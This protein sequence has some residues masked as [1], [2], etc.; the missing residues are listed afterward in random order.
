MMRVGYLTYG[1]DRD[2]TGIGRYVIELARAL[3]AVPDGPEIVLLTTEREDRHD[4][5]GRFER[6][7]L[8]ACHLLPALMTVGNGA[9]SMATAR[10][11]LDLVHDPNGVA[12][13]FGPRMGA[14]RIVTLYDALVFLY[15][16]THNNLDVWRYRWM[17]PHA[18]KRTDM[19]VTGSENSRQDLRRFLA[20]PDAKL[21]VCTTATNARFAPVADT[22]ER[23]AVLARYG[24]AYPYLLYVGNVTARKNIARLLEAYARVRDRHPGMHLVIG[25]KRQWKAD[26]IDATDHRLAL[27]EYVHFTGYINDD[28][29]PALYSGAEAFVFPSLYEGFGIPPLE[30]MAC[31]TPVVTSN[32]S[33]LP[34]AVGDAALTVDP[35]DVAGLAAA[36]ETILTDQ[37]L[38]ADLRARGLLRAARYTWEQTAT[39]MRAI[40]QEVLNRG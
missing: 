17:L 27:Q 2:P 20:V 31:G 33:S 16:E 19:V 6:H 37:R 36:I 21:R 12:P 4:L 18:I 35:Y 10:H 7:A 34:E 23:R 8:P 40:Y 15:P 25:G 39:Q 22:G 1:L 32:T 28:D 3:G 11:H 9:L 30:A 38:R 29:L 5:W 13:F 14:K 24:I 26:E